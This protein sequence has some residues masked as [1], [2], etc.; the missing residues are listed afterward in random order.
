MMS[1]WSSAI[2]MRWGGAPVMSGFRGGIRGETSANRSVVVQRDVVAL[3]RRSERE[4]IV[5]H[6]LALGGQRAGDAVLGL[7]EYCLL[8]D[9][10]DR[11]AGSGLELLLLGIEGLLREGNR[12]LV[13]LD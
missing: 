6:G 10:G 9:D 4:V 8:L 11:R 12:G 3:E 1:A 7:G 13:G 5:G 2:R